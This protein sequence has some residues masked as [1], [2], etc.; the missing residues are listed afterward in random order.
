[1][2][3]AQKRK[4]V[5]SSGKPK[6]TG[7]KTWPI[8][9]AIIVLF[10][11]Y[12]LL[13]RNTAASIAIGAI[14]FF[15]IIVLIVLEFINGVKEEGYAKNIIEVVIAIAVVVAL[16]FGLGAL[17]HTSEPLN[18][19]PSCS[20]LPYLHRGDMII[21]EGVSGISGLRAPVISMSAHE[22][23]VMNSSMASES[24]SCVAYNITSQSV[25]VSQYI[26]PG[27]SIGLYDSAMRRIVSQDE[28]TGAITFTCG[29]R[30]VIFQNGTTL[31]EAY[32]T[33][34]TIAGNTI[35]GDR[36]NSVI[37]Y[38]TV[39][40]DSF[41][42]EGDAYIVHRIYAII[43]VSGSYYVLTKGDNNPGLDIQYGNYPIPLS[44]VEG[45]VIASVPYIG[46]LKLILSNSFSRPLGCNFVT[47]H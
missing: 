19:V 27:Y 2:A 24:L 44:N 12:I 11:L 33:A 32:T 18:V 38:K 46:Y 25:Q 41:Y 47:Q 8:Y 37:V 1:M 20:M 7:Q 5:P 4:K 21:I 39:P 22:F 3:K 23:A 10:V 34:I 36:G 16:W 29:A 28:Q 14:L 40:A 45:K 17:L 13:Q 35:I 42:Q 30:N 26:S 6:S 9:I 43:N 31:R 15:L